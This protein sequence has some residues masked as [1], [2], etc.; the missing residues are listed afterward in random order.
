MRT[1]AHL[2]DPHFGRLDQA[3]LDALQ[4]SVI[5]ARPDLVVVS[6][7]LTQRARASEFEDARRFLDALPFPKLVVPG[8]H[9]VPFFNVLR[10]GLRPFAKYRQF[11]SAD[12]EPFYADEEVAVLGINT[13][14]TSRLKSGRINRQ[15]VARGCEQ[16]ATCGP[17]VTRVVV[18]HHPFDLPTTQGRGALVGRARMAMTD[19]ARCQVDLFLAGHFHVSHAGSS[20]LR[21]SIPGHAAVVVQAGTAASTRGRGELNSFNLIRVDRPM[22]DVERWTWDP[23][24]GVFAPVRNELFRRMSHGWSRIP[25]AA[26]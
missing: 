7:D 22:L 11:I 14:R 6:G 20:A 5:G 4:A 23:E 8:N 26:G 25:G 13:V 12:T 10:R 16:L 24:R 18:T 15:Q 21:Y 19:F 2:S 17:T 9:D 1:L 3:V